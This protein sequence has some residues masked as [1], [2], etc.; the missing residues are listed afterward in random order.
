M[1]YHQPHCGVAVGEYG[2]CSQKCEMCGADYRQLVSLSFSDYQTG[3]EGRGEFLLCA[4]CLNDLLTS[5][6]ADWAGKMGQA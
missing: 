4:D 2:R 6:L 3:E 1:Q 5:G